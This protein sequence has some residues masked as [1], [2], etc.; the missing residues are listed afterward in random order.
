MDDD[1]TTITTYVFCAKHLKLECCTRPYDLYKKTKT[2]GRKLMK[3]GD[4]VNHV[5]AEEARQMVA[6]FTSPVREFSVVPVAPDGWCILGAAL[7]KETKAFAREYLK[8]DNNAALL[9]DSQEVRQLWSLL[10]PR[11]KSTVQTFWSSD[12]ADLLIPML[13]QHLNAGDKRAV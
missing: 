3:I 10:D 11:R 7:V 1:D 5:Q 12:A 6:I 13:S 4:F 2:K 8:D 9:G